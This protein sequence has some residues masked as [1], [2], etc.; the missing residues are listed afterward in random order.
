MAKISVLLLL[1]L[2]VSFALGYYSSQMPPA[3]WRALTT[4]LLFSGMWWGTHYSTV[5]LG[6]LMERY[7]G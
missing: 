1:S 3:L 2:T 7:R 5:W 6:R 4:I